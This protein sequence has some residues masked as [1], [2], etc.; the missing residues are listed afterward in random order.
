MGIYNRERVKRNIKGE[1][2]LGR[3]N[4]QMGGSKKLSMDMWPLTSK[5]TSPPYYNPPSPFLTLQLHCISL[6]RS[7]LA[8]TLR[9]TEQGPDAAKVMRLGD[10]K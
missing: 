7:H 6:E 1:S 3:D 4:P 10:T 8:M 5:I 9:D 2:G